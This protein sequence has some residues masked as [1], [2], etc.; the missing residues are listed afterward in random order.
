L[1]IQ[2]GTTQLI[3]V[4]SQ[5][6]LTKLIDMVPG[7]ISNFPDMVSKFSGTDK[8]PAAKE[9]AAEYHHLEK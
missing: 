7:I 3:N 1:V 2:N 4:K 8:K 6:S 5:D 9:E